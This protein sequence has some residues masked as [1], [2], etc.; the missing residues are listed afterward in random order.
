ALDKDGFVWTWGQNNVGQLGSGSSSD[1]AYAQKVL[2]GAQ[3]KLKDADTY[4]Q[5][6]RAI[7]AGD[8]F[9]GAVDK[10]GFVYT[11]G[12]N[13]RG[14]L[15]S[16]GTGNAS[17]PIR[18]LAGVSAPG[19]SQSGLTSASS[20]ISQYMRDV[21]ELAAGEDH[22][23][24]M[25][26]DG[27]VY[28]WGF[29]RYGQLGTEYTTT[30]AV[31]NNTTVYG[32]L[33]VPYQVT[34]AQ[35][36]PGRY[37]TDNQVKVSRYL[38]E[39]V[40][41][42]AGDDASWYINTDRQLLMSGSFT[43]DTISDNDTLGTKVIFSAVRPT[44]FTVEGAP[45]QGVDANGDKYPIT[46]AKGRITSV[47][48][49]DT[50]ADNLAFVTGAYEDGQS[51]AW[52]MGVNTYGQLGRGYTNNLRTPLTQADRNEI[53]SN[54]PVQVYAPFED[55]PVDSR[56]LVT[57]PNVVD[58]A[59]GDNHSVFYQQDGSVLDVGLGTSGQLGDGE[60]ASR[61]LPVRVGEGDTTSA[62]ITAAKVVDGATTVTS[63]TVAPEFISMGLKQKLE[64]DVSAVK[65]QLSDGFNLYEDGYRI[66]LPDGAAITFTS[67]DDSVGM[68]LV[69]NEKKSSVTTSA[70]G[71]DVTL[72]S[73]NGTKTGVV[74]VYIEITSGTTTVRGQIRVAITDVEVKR[75]DIVVSAGL[76]HS[77]A[78]AEDGTLW[79]WGSNSNGQLG[80]GTAN[81]PTYYEY[82]YH[83]RV[84][85]EGEEVLFRDV[86]AGENW[87][88]AV[89]MDG[90]LWAWGSGYTAQPAELSLTKSFARN[91]DD[92]V[93]VDVYN[94]RAIALATDGTV[95]TWTTANTQ[96]VEI[97]LPAGETV[98]QVAAGAAHYML[99][100][101]SGKVYTWGSNA[102]GQLGIA[103]TAVSN[104]Y[105]VVTMND[106]GTG[107]TTERVNLNVLTA[108]N[109]TVT[110]PTPVVV[111][112][113]AIKDVPVLVSGTL[114]SKEA[115][116]RTLK[117][118]TS[119]LTQVVQ[120]PVMVQDTE[121][122]GTPKVDGDGNPVMVQKTEQVQ[123]KDAEGNLL[124]LDEEKKQPDMET[125]YV[126]RDEVQSVPYGSKT[127]AEV[128]AGDPIVSISAGAY[129]SAAVTRSGKV[130]IWGRNSNY[131]AASGDQDY[132]YEVNGHQLHLKADGNNNSVIVRPT[133]MTFAANGEGTESARYAWSEEEGE[134]L[135]TFT[136][137]AI[138]DVDYVSLGEN[139][140]LAVTR[141][142]LVYSWGL[143][144]MG[145]AGIGADPDPVSG[146]SH[147]IG[148]TGSIS[149]VGTD[150]SAYYH[151]ELPTQVN[152][153]E[154]WNADAELY[155]QGVSALDAGNTHTLAARSDGFV[156]AW[157]SNENY[158]LGSAA[159][160]EDTVTSTTTRIVA[161]PVQVGD[162]EARTLAVYRVSVYASQADYDAGKDPVRT[163]LF[164]EDILTQYENDQESMVRMIDLVEGEIAVIDY[165]DNEKNTAL[166]EVYLS[167]FNL[168][169]N[170]R[171]LALRAMDTENVKNIQWTSADPTTATVKASGNV[172]IISTVAGK[173]GTTLV[174][175]TNHVSGHTGT[176]RVTVTQQPEGVSTAGTMASSVVTGREFS[177]ALRSDGTVWTW[178]LNN[179]GQLGDGTTITRTVPTQVQIAPETPG[180]IEYLTDIVAIAAGEKHLVMLNSRGQVFTT[181]DN[182]YGQLGYASTVNASDA[183]APYKN[184]YAVAVRFED[185][186]GKPLEDQPV[187]TA[188]A[189][190]YDHTLA[191]SRG[192]E[193]VENG[194]RTSGGD[195][196]AWG[197]NNS[198]QIGIGTSKGTGSVTRPV[199][200]L[201]G[202]SAS[203]SDYLG[204]IA[205]I[206]AGQYNSFAIRTDGYVLGWGNNAYGQLGDG[207]KENRGQPVFMLKGQSGSYT[208]YEADQY[209]N[210]QMAAGSIYME[211]VYMVSAGLD[212]TLILVR[213]ESANEDLTARTEV[214]AVGNNSDGQLGTWN[215]NDRNDS[216]PGTNA[217]ST[218]PVRVLYDP[219]L[220][221]PHNWFGSTS[222]INDPRKDL[223][224]EI[225]GVMA[226]EKYSFALD[227][228]GRLYAWGSNAYGQLGV[229]TTTSTSQAATG[230]TLPTPVLSGLTVES[231]DESFN[232]Q[233]SSIR[234]L[235]VRFSHAIALKADGTVWGWG[236]NT[237]WKLGENA[238]TRVATNESYRYYNSTT[239][240][241]HVYPV[242]VGEVERTLMLVADNDT[243]IQI[244]DG[245]ERVNV[246]AG[247]E[248]LRIREDQTV[249]IS[250]D[251]IRTQYLSGLDLYDRNGAQEKIKD[252]KASQLMVSFSDTLIATA[253]ADD[254]NSALI[255]KAA[256]LDPDEGR[257][258]GHTTVAIRYTEPGENGRSYLMLLQL[259]VS[260]K[261]SPEPAAATQNG[262]H[263]QRERADVTVPAIANGAAHSVA[264]KADG[265]VWA[266]GLGSSGQ[267]GLG[268]V[269]SY[270]FPIQVLR[271][272]QMVYYYCP[273]CDE[274]F[275]ESDF[276]HD[277]ELKHICARQNNAEIT[278]NKATMESTGENLHHIVALS[279]NQNYT[280]ALDMWGNV[281]AWGTRS[282]VVPGG[283]ASTPKRV[284]FANSYNEDNGYST[285]DTREYN[286][287]EDDDVVIVA[288][289]AGYDHA[290]ALDSMGEVW[291]WGNNGFGQLGNDASTYGANS[292][293]W[294][295]TV[296]NGGYWYDYDISTVY[297]AN[298]EDSQEPTLSALDSSVDPVHV[299]RGSAAS[300][301]YHYLDHV[302]DI[303]AGRYFTVALR[304]DGTVWA[305]GKN[306]VYQLG[307][308]TIT[309]GNPT[310][311][312]KADI[313]DRFAPIQVK[314]E[315]KDE[316]GKVIGYSALTD[317]ISISAGTEHAIALKADGTVY[318]WG[319]T[320]LY[321][322]GTSDNSTHVV[323]TDIAASSVMTGAGS[324]LTGI[325]SI[326]AGYENDAALDTDG[327][328]WTWGNNQYGQYGNNTYTSV[329][330]AN[331]K[332][333]RQVHAGEGPSTIP[334]QSTT[335][336]TGNTATTGYLTNI[337]SVDAG[338]S[339]VLALSRD[340]YVYGW[341]LNG[342]GEVGNVSTGDTATYNTSKTTRVLM[343][344]L[345][346][347][348]AG[349]LLQITDAQITAADAEF[350]AANAV[351]KSTRGQAIYYAAERN[352]TKYGGTRTGDGYQYE[353]QGE[354][355]PVSIQ[356]TQSQTMWV[357]T[358]SIVEES[359]KG[360]NL[361]WDVTRRDVNTAIADGEVRNIAEYADRF[362][363][364]SS[365]EGVITAERAEGPDGL[366]GILLKPTKERH[367]SATI[368]IVDKVNLYWGS[369]TVTVFNEGLNDDLDPIVTLASV[370]SGINTSYA[371]KQNGTVWAW[372]DNRNDNLGLNGEFSESTVKDETTPATDFL[373][374][375]YRA[376]S[377][378]DPY[379]D[380]A[381][382]KA[383]GLADEYN[384]NIK[385]YT[386]AYNIALKAM[387]D[388]KWEDA[389]IAFL[390][391]VDTLRD[392][393]LKACG[394]ISSTLNTLQSYVDSEALSGTETIFADL[395][396]ALEA[397]AAALSNKSEAYNKIYEQVELMTGSGADASNFETLVT[398]LG[399]LTNQMNGN[400]DPAVA[401][402]LAALQ[403][404]DPLPDLA[405]DPA[406]VATARDSFELM[407]RGVAE[408]NDPETVAYYSAAKDAMDQM[409]IDV[410]QDG[411]AVRNAIAELA[412]D[413]GLTNEEGSAFAG[414]QDALERAARQLN[415]EK[416]KQAP[417]LADVAFYTAIRTAIDNNG[418]PYPG[419]PVIIGL[420][421]NGL[422]ASSITLPTTLGEGDYPSA[423]Q[424]N[425]DARDALAGRSSVPVVAVD[426]NSAAAKQFS[427]G[428][429]TALTIPESYVAIRQNAFADVKTLTT[430]NYY[431]AVPKDTAVSDL[432]FAGSAITTVSTPKEQIEALSAS[433]I[434]GAAQVLE[435][436]EKANEEEE[437]GDTVSAQIKLPMQVAGINGIGKLG[438]ITTKS[439]RGGTATNSPIISLSVNADQAE[440]T[441]AGGHVLALTSEGDVYAWGYN[442]YGQLGNGS[443]AR[444][445]YPVRV[446]AGTSP[447]W[448]AVDN[449]GERHY[450]PKEEE[451]IGWT[452]Q[453][454]YLT[455]VVA[456]SAGYD[457][458]LAL[459]KDGTVLAWGNSSSGQAGDYI[460]GV[461]RSLTPQFVRQ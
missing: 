426:F 361:H 365:N 350:A 336:G 348:R 454:H 234:S 206:T 202:Q 92:R 179:V 401:N 129:T 155:F 216:N 258:V 285:P 294:E 340:G 168:K 128:T 96:P 416:A 300:A 171:S 102:N 261:A 203:D 5:N 124:W 101:A 37:D 197:R 459:L 12:A 17:T 296:Y 252:L 51:A 431:A 48:A 379:L 317:V 78:L 452:D 433:G 70:A 20:S 115:E 273:Y 1:R 458:S 409:D 190:G 422:S 332:I 249:V 46:D 392:E 366:T 79:L 259:Y 359:W 110:V 42:V 95:Y 427:D 299:V 118:V 420:K 286:V 373:W 148:S 215:N 133:L 250:M 8:D 188:I 393:T 248:I 107:L 4:L 63:Y 277:G 38:H 7:A 218:T 381:I 270:T 358:S 214:Y 15:G 199:Q 439:S 150:A 353:Y 356:L 208:D 77:A 412:G 438:D 21:V 127:L 106:A 224:I 345:V 246:S 132:V 29:N 23:I 122:D 324:A 184:N 166:V 245:A 425:K 154:A 104:A 146:S 143:N 236:Q 406:P 116:Y 54:A 10:N 293:K 318:G 66:D 187:I 437:T 145:Q 109:T 185:A 84:E 430:V 355:M 196:W 289:S 123:K 417:H 165:S 160:Y 327:A 177:A 134:F 354:E 194:K 265:T 60:T 303:A 93:T 325:K 347:A 178:G 278:L 308:A 283:S 64:I 402:T 274:L 228:E 212:H 86:K 378:A 338:S 312:G 6:I 45:I 360:Y 374:D 241:T 55:Q 451:M 311:A 284:S 65:I 59:I 445:T 151:A 159:V 368:V 351:I 81:V 229:T 223:N 226:G 251:A 75:S 112:G 36:E 170:S 72:V 14:Q 442:A 130:Y 201:K 181:G 315:V 339:T 448:Y 200:V 301:N 34:R 230:L 275:P 389:R 76:N 398:I 320:F 40:E 32:Y 322:S 421:D 253:A 418:N 255:L 158:K 329:T 384:E 162:M 456:I 344:M 306:N 288:I 198:Y 262:I 256:A 267:L 460:N 39:V 314:S 415:Q 292:T 58:V 3:P 413:A 213:V 61:N 82:P 169:V 257:T 237:N 455:G 189:A 85:K 235:S 191:L 331:A 243:P 319:R 414:A 290:V 113:Y 120:V 157:G 100:T 195:V 411:S 297:V 91:S 89:D 147:E 346:G 193:V 244:T 74:T 302:V 383:Q 247:S 103:G 364:F 111:D 18:V 341:G 335:A 186:D 371:I 211:N 369:F 385:E 204:S 138:T 71:A 57:L 337:I 429:L 400:E 333:A 9:A 450:M 105:N 405:A 242:R 391:A 141:D 13:D 210:G 309:G 87:T 173:Y 22:F 176:L 349:N 387:S 44:Y 328:V 121:A 260:R 174:R 144:Q 35:N 136:G 49:F 69:G 395:K 382:N 27:A 408:V 357:D 457:H 163:Y 343:P 153:G 363:A 11:W 403:K 62:R 68:F 156:F 268:T 47:Y 52:M 375:F 222:D 428:K 205:A 443:T 183:A 461:S 25:M 316:T 323:D 434:F 269:N 182:T 231:T 94:G 440:N 330:A 209:N 298:Q 149:S 131:E 225:V 435:A 272:E 367:G 449:N 80:T 24:A 28:A 362:Y 240:R 453:T 26:D 446:L 264:L 326:S 140:G 137:A 227:S 280:L 282:N 404:N 386:G 192:T 304:S 410:I 180:K 233:I 31:S 432:S 321:N 33:T 396:A 232:K 164:N 423:F 287:N 56:A 263:E 342:S 444:T 254:A 424:D 172:A 126:T 167:G 135:P 291:A 281:W 370:Y 220:P 98:T 175:V 119:A 16:H 313:L 380:N 390:A 388:L 271:G 295:W 436:P 90:R 30:T 419:L 407:M 310:A 2:I 441:P 99:L 334:S 399:S 372:G 83:L 447:Y 139:H 142:G 53:N 394:T 88:L 73:A 152:K 219:S 108:P 276:D 307:Q 376:Q 266:W 117:V 221:E 67:G 377:T 43:S 19:T 125:V 161:E 114:G 238:T 217:S 279:A 207:T 50:G 352:D 97:D 239:D 41:I 305:W 397:L